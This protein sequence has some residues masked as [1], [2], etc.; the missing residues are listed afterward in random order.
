[1]LSTLK[2]RPLL[3]TF[4]SSYLYHVHQCV[5]RCRAE[6]VNARR[7][8]L[9]RLVRVVTAVKRRRKDVE[10]LGVCKV[11]WCNYPVS[12]TL[13]VDDLIGDAITD[14]RSDV[15]NLYC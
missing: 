8:Q 7:L 15:V 6:C 13:L 9:Q 12:L 10:A 5:L 14:M 4:F 3:S 11:A 2:F 1:M